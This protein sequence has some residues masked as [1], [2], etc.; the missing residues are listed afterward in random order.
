[1]AAVEALKMDHYL[2][3]KLTVFTGMQRELKFLSKFCS[4]EAPG[5]TVFSQRSNL[6]KPSPSAASG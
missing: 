2:N 6:N 1:M 3:N 5:E 4:P